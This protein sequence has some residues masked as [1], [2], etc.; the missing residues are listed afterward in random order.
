MMTVLKPDGW[1]T[2]APRLFAS[3]VDELVEFMK[4]VFDAQGEVRAG[5]P[6]EMKIGDSLVMV[7]DG[8]GLRTPSSAF[9]HVYVEDA[10]VAYQR[11]VAAGADSI[12]PP[13]DMPYG[14]RR[15]TFR[16]RWGNHWQ[17]AT[18]RG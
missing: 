13:A 10:D 6:A 7:S 4:L 14:D 5:R 1:P 18:F 17:V 9:L 16:D 3:E 8:G 15:A 12:E 2:V 11:A